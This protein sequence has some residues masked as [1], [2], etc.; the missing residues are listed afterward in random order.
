MNR[1]A[2]RSHST[3]ATATGSPHSAALIAARMKIR[4]ASR[5]RPTTWAASPKPAM[6]RVYS[7]PEPSR[8]ITYSDRNAMIARIRRCIRI[9]EA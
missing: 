1:P 5:C 4:L 9:V 8:L 2:P 7:V 6:A 3:W